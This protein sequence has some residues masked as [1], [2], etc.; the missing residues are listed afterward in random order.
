MVSFLVFLAGVPLGLAATPD[1]A[2]VTATADWRV[3]ETAHLRVHA[4]AALAG[5]A[6]YAA[7]EETAVV[8]LLDFFGGPLSGKVDLYAWADESEAARV[9]GKPLAFAVPSSLTIHT[10]PRHTPGHELTHIV[11]GDRFPGRWNRFI[12]EGTAVLFDQT[13]RDRLAMARDVVKAGGVTGTVRDAWSTSAGE[14]A[15]FYPIAGAFAERL[16]ARGGKDKFLAL[17][18]EPSLDGARRVYGADLESWI[19]GFQVDVGMT[20]NPTLDA[21]RA[22]AR[23]RMAADKQRFN[24]SELTEIE[25][26]YKQGSMKSDAGIAAYKDLVARFPASNRAGCAMLYVAR[27]AKGAEREAGLRRAFADFDDTWYGDGTRV[28]A[29]AR[30]L[31]ALQLAADGKVDEAKVLAAQVAATDP[32]A[33]DHN[34]FSLVSQ[35]R[36][37]GLVP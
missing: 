27:T 12:G 6:A 30:T 16:L 9:L 32:D 4:P 33:V 37:A 14:E 15:W 20:P 23:A 8:A 19:D 25:A 31:L 29:Y 22:R 2:T 18:A 26:L 1:P 13:R 7:Q 3:L 35:L 36:D 24:A 28:G 11:V 5:L 21:L 17:L 34:G 10:S